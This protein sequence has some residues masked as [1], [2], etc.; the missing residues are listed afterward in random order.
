M[1]SVYPTCSCTV[2]G[3]NAELLVSQGWGP[4]ACWN[5]E[6]PTACCPLCAGGPPVDFLFICT[7][8]RVW[9]PRK[10]LLL[11]TV[12]FRCACSSALAVSRI[13]HTPGFGRPQPRGDGRERKGTVAASATSWLFLNHT[14]ICRMG[15]RWKF[16]MRAKVPECARAVRS[17]HP[18]RLS[19]RCVGR[20]TALGAIS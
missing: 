19:I 5:L 11:A 4:S 1:S 6:T 18:P 16:C 3:L 17:L 10:G 15:V 9:T 14:H 8:S 12:R 20:G 13:W 7:L 2:L